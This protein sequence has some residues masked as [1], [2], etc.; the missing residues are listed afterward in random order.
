MGRDDDL[1][2]EWLKTQ[3]A[4][5]DGWALD[6]LRCA[7]LGLD[8]ESRSDDWVAV[9]VGPSGKEVSHRAAGPLDALRG[10]RGRTDAMR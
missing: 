4:L 7:S 6:G 10:L 3:E 9:A 5:P 1:A 8:E 2:R